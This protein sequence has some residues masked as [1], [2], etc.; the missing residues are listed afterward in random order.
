ML[1]E[2]TGGER[3]VADVEAVQKV[4]PSRY[5][6]KR[7][8]GS[9]GAGAVY[10]ARDAVL[11]RTV[12]I[13]TLHDAANQKEAM[14]FQREAQLAGSLKH[15]NVL[16][17]LDF[18]LTET[19]EPYLV[20]EYVKGESLE[21][22]L[23]RKGPMP[24]PAALDLFE[25]IAN[26]LEHAHR[27]SI[28]HRDVKP[29][30]I[31]LVEKNSRTVAQIVDFGLAKLQEEDL[32][33]TSSGSGIG[34]P[35]YM[36]PE[37]IRGE[38]VDGRTDIY[39]FGCLMFTVLT[40]Q[41]PFRGS[42]ALDTINMHLEEQPPALKDVAGGEF[43][44]H[45]EAVVSKCLEKLPED[46]FSSASDVLGALQEKP[47]SAHTEQSDVGS[48]K[49]A[50]VVLPVA[51]VAAIGLIGFLIASMLSEPK[52]EHKEPVPEDNLFAIAAIP[53][54]KGPKEKL[55]YEGKN[56]V[57]VSEEGA[58]DADL[59]RFLKSPQSKKVTRMELRLSTITPKG[60]ARLK[61][62][63]LQDLVF[64]SHKIDVETARAIA[65]IRTLKRLQIGETDDE[66]D[67]NALRELDAI[68]NFDTLAIEVE[69]ID[70][71]FIENAAKLKNIRNLDLEG[72]SGL[73]AIKWE[74][75]NSLKH[76]SKLNLN[77]TDIRDDDIRKLVCLN[78]VKILDLK[79]SRITD[80]GLKQ[81]AQME[82]LHTI[83]LSTNGPCTPATAAKLLEERRIR[84]NFSGSGE[85][86]F[87][88]DYVKEGT[89][90]EK[91]KE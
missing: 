19:N 34:T 82:N 47:V 76:L 25:Q 35:S 20:L 16:S 55:F 66:I 62:L 22:R 4:L 86:E 29:S 69:R 84:C 30:N 42:T 18:G 85:R 75:L 73:P 57:W 67:P 27:K 70:N 26:G 21:R 48:A 60:L 37:Q 1:E 83:N 33:L 54:E 87:W 11:D 56:K 80:V 10:E 41:P 88:K 53:S 58:T 44:S 51:I 91:P 46:R 65:G 79:L 5:E 12:A 78:K 28:V 36:S 50:Q 72:C 49:G 2:I 68:P 32:K 3:N 90:T 24:V 39:S 43:P 81:L 77:R 17:V 74:P 7:V 31:M 38:A 64:P 52:V 8:I 63:P 9:G 13:K 61:A 89:S 40:G 59:F 23:R 14:R 15:P 71:R 45:L 6:I